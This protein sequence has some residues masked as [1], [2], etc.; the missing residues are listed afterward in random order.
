[1]K[2]KY[3]RCGY[4]KLASAWALVATLASNAA[5]P[6]GRANDRPNCFW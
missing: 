2:I 5:A 4:W 1:M 3:S 6:T